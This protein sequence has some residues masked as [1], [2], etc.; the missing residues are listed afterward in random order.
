MLQSRF[1]RN[2]LESGNLTMCNGEWGNWS[3]GLGFVGCWG[4]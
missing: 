1:E 2:L 3:D 4:E